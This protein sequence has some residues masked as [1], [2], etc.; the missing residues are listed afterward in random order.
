MRVDV[1]T[2]AEL[3]RLVAARRTKFNSVRTW[4]PELD[5]WFASGHEAEQ[6]VILLRRQ[7]AGE[8]RDLAFQV[9][10]PLDVAD[11]VVCTYVADFVYD[12]R[13]PDRDT[14][15]GPAWVHVVADAKSP[16]TRTAVYR[17][18]K[19]LV[20]VCLGIDVVEL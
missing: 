4:V 1:V 14:A 17:L 15:M 19:R 3:R 8:V 20:R 9:A 18:K 5:R 6:A 11:Q 12:E 10:Y 13:R 16:P 2:V 7:Q